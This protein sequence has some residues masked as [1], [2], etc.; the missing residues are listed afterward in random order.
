MDISRAWWLLL[1][2]GLISI[3]KPWLKIW[4]LLHTPQLGDY[5]CSWVL[6]TKDAKETVQG[7]SRFQIHAAVALIA[8]LT[9]PVYVQPNASHQW[10]LQCSKD[11]VVG[12]ASPGP[13]VLTWLELLS[14]ATVLGAEM[15]Q[16]PPFTWKFASFP[17]L[18]SPRK[19]WPMWGSTKIQHPRIAPS[20]R[21]NLTVCMQRGEVYDPTAFSW[22]NVVV[23]WTLPTWRRETLRDQRHCASWFSGVIG[24]PNWRRMTT[25][26][27][28]LRQFKD[29]SF[30][31]FH[32]SDDD[33][34]TR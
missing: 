22:S 29:E 1:F 18:V 31:K 5:S 26:V 17:I 23:S 30:E 11:Q 33:I 13:I 9:V 8:W 27:D 15:G 12:E 28:S 21:S 3:N 25:V 2:V 4:L 34:I 32:C 16:S 6:A 20:R 19:Q 7:Y 14:C 10:I 24:Y